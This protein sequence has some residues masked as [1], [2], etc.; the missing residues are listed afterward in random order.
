MPTI[1][2]RLR[3]LRQ[4]TNQHRWFFVEYGAGPKPELPSEEG[5]QEYPGLMLLCLLESDREAATRLGAFWASKQDFDASRKEL[6]CAIGAEE[7]EQSGFVRD[8]RTPQK[9]LR[10]RLPALLVSLVAVLGA[11]DALQNHFSHLL[12]APQLSLDLGGSEPLKQLETAPLALELSV[13]NGSLREA[14]MVRLDTIQIV[15]Q[16]PASQPARLERPK[17]QVSIPAGG[18]NTLPIRSAALPPGSYRLTAA[19]NA[20]V[21][22]LRGWHPANAARDVTI[23]AELQEVS[24][25]L[26]L[27]RTGANNAWLSGT[28]RVGKE[29]QRGL[30]CTAVVTHVAQLEI[31]GVQGFA[32]A[33]EPNLLGGPGKEVASVQ[34]STGPLSAFS[35]RPF[36]I[37]LV[38]HGKTDWKKVTGSTR[39]DCSEHVNQEKKT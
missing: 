20:K 28:L 14:A 10:K 31:L 24:T 39:V 36:R 3:E 2:D 12:E 7:M 17:L 15:R 16:G 18:R 32:S 19:V 22:E 35:T 11:L 23:W 6:E 8:L 5:F 26:V 4:T 29:T 34:W 9:P 25:P 38:G 1:A 21:G 13:A 33:S 27:E 37:R 30:D